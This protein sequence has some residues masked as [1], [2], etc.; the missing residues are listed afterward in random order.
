MG[1]RKNGRGLRFPCECVS[2]Q[3]GYSDPWA[4]IT[5]RKLLNDGTK[6]RV[7]NCLA[8]QPKTIA[9][10]AKELGLSP[11]AIH[12]H[13]GDML[14][15]ELL[16]ESPTK[17]QHPAENYYEPNFPIIN[18][19]D[20][21]MFDKVCQTIAVQMASAFEKSL[22]ELDRSLQK[23]ALASN[24]WRFADVAHFCYANAQRSARAILEQR[25]VLPPRKKHRN[26][27]AWVFWAEESDSA[28]AA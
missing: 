2:V 10:L 15:S 25:G 7:L 23:N 5:Q 24:G 16:R 1:L 3:R 17:K 21:A 26:G 8:R 18:A 12:A 22:E 6:E 19:A 11:A 4:E 13:V 28:S 20:R 27:A 9:G 14:D